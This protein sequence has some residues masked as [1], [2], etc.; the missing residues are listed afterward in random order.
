MWQKYSG[1]KIDGAVAIDPTA[2]GYLLDIA[3]AISEKL[4]SAHG[5]SQLIRAGQK[6]ASQRRLLVWSADESIESTLRQTDLSGT[7]EPGSRPFAGFTTTNATGGK[8]DYYLQRSMTYSHTGCAT[9]TTTSTFRLT[10]AAPAGVLPSYVTIRA[11]HPTYPTR[12]A[13]NKVL[14]S[15]YTTAR[16]QVDLVTVDGVKTLVAP[17]SEH[18][19]TVFTVAIELK[20]GS[21][22]T[23]TVRSH[24]PARTGSVQILKQPSVNPLVVSVHESPC[25]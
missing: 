17:Q 11:D 10:N 23:G 7:L 19:L 12:P 20:R 2:I 8:L 16:A 1:E 9:A 5:S 3:S 6:A 13:D 22:H 15:Y 25:T 18:G 21:T 24:E 14:V 4:I